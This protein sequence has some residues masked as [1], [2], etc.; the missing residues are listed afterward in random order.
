LNTLSVLDDV[1][2]QLRE[3]MR[4]KD[5]EERIWKEKIIAYIRNH[6]SVQTPVIYDAFEIYDELR[7]DLYS[8][9][10]AIRSRDNFKSLLE[11]Y[12]KLGLILRYK[13]GWCV[14]EYVLE[15][16]AREL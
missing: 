7:M 8:E 3:T 10:A 16:C 6:P 9:A 13:N 12:A 14:P 5:E 4:Q 11:Y 2:E 1:F 15:V